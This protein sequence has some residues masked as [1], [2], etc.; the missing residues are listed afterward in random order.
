MGLQDHE[1]GAWFAPGDAVPVQGEMTWSFLHRVAVCY[2]LEVGELW[3][4]GGGSG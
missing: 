1:L 3:R 4:G 2:G